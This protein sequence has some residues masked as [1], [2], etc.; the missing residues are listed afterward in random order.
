MS[1]KKKASKASNKKKNEAD[2]ATTI[3]PITEA[4]RLF[5]AGDYAGARAACGEGDSEV[6]ERL[7]VDPIFYTIYAGG[8]ALIG[9]LAALTM[10]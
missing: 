6:K 8:L 10:R 1:K 3:A 2:R 7:A 4:Q 5:D 9:V